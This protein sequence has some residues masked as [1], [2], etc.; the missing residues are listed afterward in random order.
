MPTQS[1]K[2]SITNKMVTKTITDHTH[3]L[4]EKQNLKEEFK[5]KIHINY[6]ALKLAGANV[7]AS[8]RKGQI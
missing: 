3:H 4:V 1:R 6:V 2:Q 8:V 5:L 7:V